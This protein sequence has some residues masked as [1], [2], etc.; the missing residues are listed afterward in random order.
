MNSKIWNRR[1]EIFSNF[2]EQITRG[3]GGLEYHG[4]KIGSNIF[5]LNF[6][7]NQKRCKMKD[8]YEFLDVNPSA[9]TRRVEKLVKLKLLSRKASKKDRRVVLLELTPNGENLYSKF[10]QNRQLSM[11]TFQ[12]LVEP[13]AADI[14][15]KVLDKLVEIGPPYMHLEANEIKKQTE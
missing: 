13:S 10:I 2:I 12:N 3:I 5:L 9:A 8:I 4:E 7:K 14:F 6:I 1:I 11:K 15:F